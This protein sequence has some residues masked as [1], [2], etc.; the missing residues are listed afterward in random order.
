MKTV[1]DYAWALIIIF[2][3][4][5]IGIIIS[6]FIYIYGKIMLRKSGKAYNPEYNESIF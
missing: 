6:P 1:F 5:M 4:L 2:I 3:L